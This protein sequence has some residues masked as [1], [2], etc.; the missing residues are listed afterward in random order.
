MLRRDALVRRVD[1]RRVHVVEQLAVRI[2]GGE[3]RTEVLEVRGCVAMDVEVH[4]EV[5]QVVDE[6]AL[7]PEVRVE[8]LE[9]VRV[10]EATDAA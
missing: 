6:R 9:V 3:R 2:A 8:L 10:G 5:E 1:R 4:A 7:E